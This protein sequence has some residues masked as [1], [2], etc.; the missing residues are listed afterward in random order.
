MQWHDVT[1]VQSRQL[2]RLYATL[3]EVG[4]ALEAASYAYFAT[5]IASLS[6][7]CSD[8]LHMVTFRQGLGTAVTVHCAICDGPVTASDFQGGCPFSEL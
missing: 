6:V 4:Y 5:C 3:Q 8:H 1:A 7:T 2:R